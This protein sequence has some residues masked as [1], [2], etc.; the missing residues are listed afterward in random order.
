M[1]NLKEHGEHSCC[2]CSREQAAAVLHSHHDHTTDNSIST[3][4][5]V[6]GLHCADCAAKVE[7]ALRRQRGVT[8]VAL[9]FNTGKL[10][11]EY[12]PEQIRFADIITVIEQL[13]YAVQR[14]TEVGA[15]RTVTF[16]ISGVD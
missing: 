12:V 6:K 1:S 14:R 8:A 2:D 9:N 7:F 4:L 15:A 10:H 11:I 3:V 13:G 16:H 5:I